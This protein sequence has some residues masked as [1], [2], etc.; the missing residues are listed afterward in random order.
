MEWIDQNKE[1]HNLVSI[2]GIRAEEHMLILSQKELPV[3]VHSWEFGSRFII[4]LVSILCYASIMDC[5][6]E[7]VLE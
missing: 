6:V 1:K 7:K 3:V 2:L 5:I 4:L